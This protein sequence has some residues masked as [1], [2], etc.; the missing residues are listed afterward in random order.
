MGS[1]HVLDR[2]HKK[3]F[4]IYISIENVLMLHFKSGFISI[5]VSAYMHCRSLSNVRPFI[6]YLSLRSL[7]SP[8]HNW[9]CL[10]TTHT[11]TP[12]LPSSCECYTGSSECSV[13]NS[14]HYSSWTFPSQCSPALLFCCWTDCSSPL[15]FRCVEVQAKPRAAV[16]PPH[17]LQTPALRCTC[18][19]GQ[20]EA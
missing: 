14:L 6:S 9:I 18:Q 20:T 12:I 16:N 13:G 17:C 5:S 10:P 4:L 2:G 8:H 7:I 15:R 1:G 11:C 19:N 3:S